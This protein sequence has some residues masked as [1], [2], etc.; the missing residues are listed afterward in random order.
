MTSNKT[1]HGAIDVFRVAVEETMGGG[2]GGDTGTR[3][4]DRFKN[5]QTRRTVSG[6]GLIFFFF[7]IAFYSSNYFFGRYS[8]ITV[9]R[10][11]HYEL[12]FFFKIHS[13][14]FINYYCSR[15]YTVYKMYNFRFFLH[16]CKRFFVVNIIRKYTHKFI[17]KKN[18]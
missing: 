12:I 4:G 8:V 5:R 6:V 15:N 9:S 14:H 2:W 7:D 11:F 3:R 10:V 1:T 18:S 16:E 13:A 17:Q